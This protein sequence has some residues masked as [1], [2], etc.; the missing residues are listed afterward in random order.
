MTSYFEH[1]ERRAGRPAVQLDVVEG[2]P[3]ISVTEEHEMSP[4]RRAELEELA[5]MQL[6]P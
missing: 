6:T 4:E 1:N 5:A 2:W 3:D